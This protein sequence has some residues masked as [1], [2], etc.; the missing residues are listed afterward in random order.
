MRTT[1]AFGILW[2]LF[3]LALGFGHSGFTIQYS[4]PFA[5]VSPGEFNIWL[6]H[7][8]FFTPGSLA[9]LWSLGPKLF[10]VGQRIWVRVGEFTRLHRIICQATLVALISVA[11]RSGRIFFFRDLPVTDEE[12][13]GQF[14]GRLLATGRWMVDLDIHPIQMPT[15]FL[16]ERDGKWAP[17]DFL[18]IQL[19]W[20]FSEFT[21]T[22]LWIFAI[23]AALT[24]IIVYLTLREIFDSANWALVGSAIYALSPM[25][26]LLSFSTHAHIFSRFFL[27]L[28]ILFIFRTVRR[29][30]L[31]DAVA[32]GLAFGC[33]VLC[34]PAEIVTLTAPFWFYLGFRTF[35]ERPTLVFA[36]LLGGLPTLLVLVWHNIG[37]SG[38][39]WQTPRMAENPFP[40]PVLGVPALAF[41]E[42]PQ[43]LLRRIADNLVNNTMFT[44]LYWH[45]AIGCA[46]V[47][48]SLSRKTV[49]FLFLLGLAIHASL[50]LLHD[51]DGV[52]V[53]GPIHFSEWVVYLS[54]IATF[55]LQRIYELDPSKAKGVLSRVAAP[56]ILVSILSTTIL[57]L[58]I[59][60]SNAWHEYF[61]TFIEASLPDGSVVMA[62]RNAYFWRALP[63][64]YH[65]G[66]WVFEAR[67][68]KPDF[69]E[70][71]VILRYTTGSEVFALE[72]FP[73][74]RVFVAVP[75]MEDP[76]VLVTEVERTTSLRPG[77]AK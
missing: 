5:M 14:G 64:G 27:A 43:I 19:A 7:F 75:S 24:V 69:A 63:P 41:L 58:S 71:V 67:A 26:N 15:L 25:V 51:N 55:G 8:V 61:Y 36:I 10:A 49:P 39:W 16:L 12:Y 29:K 72:R 6:A 62:P 42:E 9:L 60:S 53:V 13:T 59:R 68:P 74:R 38:L 33:G 46:L 11:Y 17:F 32:L 34:R 66:S 56:L 30:Q 35:K 50:A 20:A 18:G 47:A 28:F 48:A 73:E 21:Q 40:N 22:G 52:R 44:L 23:A 4:P 76:F 2:I 31:V 77:S 1:A 45:G 65:N 57:G 54:V 3:G 37:V 70:R